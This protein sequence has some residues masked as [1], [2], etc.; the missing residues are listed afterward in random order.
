MSSVKNVEYVRVFQETLD[1]NRE[2]EQDLNVLERTS[3]IEEINTCNGVIANWK[4]KADKWYNN[5]WY[6]HPSTKEAK[7]LK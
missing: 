2:Y 4:T 7:Y 6:Y 3:I 1:A 5:K